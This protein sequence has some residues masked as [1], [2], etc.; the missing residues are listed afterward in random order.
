VIEDIREDLG[1]TVVMIE[2]DM[3]LVNKVSDK[4]LAINEGRFLA[5]GSASEVQDDPDVQAAYLGGEA[6]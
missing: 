1:I 4:V 2:H 5:T 6:A 3:K